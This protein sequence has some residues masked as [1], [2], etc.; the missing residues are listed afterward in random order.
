MIL[1]NAKLILE[2]GI[3]EGALATENDRIAYISGAPCDE[4]IDLNGMYLAPGFVDI[5]N[6]GSGEHWHFDHPA[7]AAAWHLQEGTT[8]LLC[9]MWRNAGTYSFEKAILNVK[10]AMSLPDSNI[11]GIHFEAPYVDPNFGSEHGK[12]W[13]INREEYLRFMELGKGIIKQWCFDPTLEGAELFA[14]TAQKENIKL[15]VCY[16]KASP[17]LLS[18]YMRYGL[19]IG[20]HILCATSEPKTM[21]G[22]TREPGSDQFVL[23]EDKMIAEVIADSLGGHVRPWYLKLIYKCKGAKGIALV[24]DCCAG[25]DTMGSDVNIIN[26]ALYGSRLTLSV[27][28]RNMRKHTGASVCDV[29]K[30]V[31][32]TPAKAVGLYSER[33]SIEPGKIADLVV[34]DEDLN[35]KGVIIN[36][37]FVRKDF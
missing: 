30:M 16:S 13:P 27:A 5:H 2:D 18:Y 7:E 29:I 28:V 12:S 32:S 14:Q 35:V 10:E 9:S 20:G 25:G 8:S 3:Q 34:L 19:R 24:S 33:G 26:G 21:F 17:D 4:G 1:K 36:G 11:R 22:G 37:K 15:A 31:T 6:H 23:Y